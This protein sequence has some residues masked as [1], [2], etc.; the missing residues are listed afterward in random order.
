VRRRAR[1]RELTSPQDAR[2]EAGASSGDRFRDAG[3]ECAA[4]ALMHGMP[5]CALRPRG[6]V[7]AAHEDG[8]LAASNLS[9]NSPRDDSMAACGAS[10]ITVCTKSKCCTAIA[11]FARDALYAALGSELTTDEVVDKLRVC[12]SVRRLQLQS[13]CE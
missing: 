6:R 8:A 1:V 2:G 11:P 5:I 9:V 7:T 13:L 3:L 4:L 12:H 10:N